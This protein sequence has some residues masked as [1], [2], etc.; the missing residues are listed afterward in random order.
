MIRPVRRTPFLR[1]VRTKLLVM[2]AVLS[3][4]LLVL[5]LYQLNNYRRSLNDQAT[6]IARIESNAA[7]GALAS[8]LDDHPDF[9]APTD[10]FTEPEARNL[11]AYLQQNTSPG[12]DS[13]IIVLDAHGHAVR[14]PS[15]VGPTPATG[16]L[17]G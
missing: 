5:S 8:W 9:A 11:Y 1:S 16:E 6:T 17:S 7:A 14:N 4:P 13:I 2:L 3:L 15:R 10:A 12:T